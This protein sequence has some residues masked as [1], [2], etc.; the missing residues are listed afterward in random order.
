MALSHISSDHMRRPHGTDHTAPQG[1]STGQDCDMLNTDQLWVTRA[2]SVLRLKLLQEVK[3]TKPSGNAVLQ[4]IGQNCNN[5]Q[6]I[7]RF[8]SGRK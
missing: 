6:C 4:H 5:V 7:R 3:Y 2:K 1:S 8:V